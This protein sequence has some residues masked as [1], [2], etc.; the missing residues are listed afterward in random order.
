MRQVLITVLTHYEHQWISALPDQQ[1]PRDL[2][3]FASQLFFQC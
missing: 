2:N 1:K 3:L